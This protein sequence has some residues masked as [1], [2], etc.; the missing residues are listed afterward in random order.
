M[1]ELATLH[2]CQ[3]GADS[4]RV[5][6]DWCSVWVECDACGY[7]APALPVEQPGARASVDVVVTAWNL[8]R[9]P[10]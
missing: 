4:A 10:R 9:G 6:R 5:R 7:A 8:V 2:P 3:C 1:S